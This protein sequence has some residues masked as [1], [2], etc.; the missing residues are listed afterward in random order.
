MGHHMQGNLCLLHK[1]SIL[2]DGGALKH[3][4]QKLI[5][6]VVLTKDDVPKEKKKYIKWSYIKT[7]YKPFFHWVAIN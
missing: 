2:C 4:Y 1:T 3:R 7:K 5:G 6:W